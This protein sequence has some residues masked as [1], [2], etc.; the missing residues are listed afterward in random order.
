MTET[1]GTGRFPPPRWDLPALPPSP[2]EIV[3]LQHTGGPPLY[4]TVAECPTCRGFARR[5]GAA[6]ERG[7]MSRAA[8]TRTE[9]VA[10]RAAFPHKPAEAR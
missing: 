9:W 6:E 3:P 2:P 7:E 4:P 8:F 10:H 5:I 1:H